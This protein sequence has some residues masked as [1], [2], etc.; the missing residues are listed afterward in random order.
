[1]IEVSIDNILENIV[2]IFFTLQERNIQDEISRKVILSLTQIVPL[3]FT[4]LQHKSQKAFSRL[5]KTVIVWSL[6]VHSL[7]F[8][9]P[10]P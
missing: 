8:L 6:L 9:M 10:G 5:V 3:Q 1:L 4:H 7:L 2:I